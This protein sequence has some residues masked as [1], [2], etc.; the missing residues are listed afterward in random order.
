MSKN[1][2]DDDDGKGTRR[3]LFEMHFVHQII[4]IGEGDN[5]IRKCQLTA[6]KGL[7]ERKST[8]KTSVQ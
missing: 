6:I 8:Q 1:N 5:E 2:D 3:A 7:N 4:L